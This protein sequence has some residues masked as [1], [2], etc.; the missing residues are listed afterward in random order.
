MAAQAIGSLYAQLGLDT[1]SFDTGIAKARGKL[2]DFGKINFSGAVKAGLGEIDGALKS[3]AG[4]AGALG[5]VLGGLGIAGTAAAAAIAVAFT[6]ARQAMAFGD[7]I[8]DTANKLRVT[9]DY[10]QELRFAAHQLGGEF[11]DADEALEGF[12]KTFGLARSGLSAKAIKPFAALGLDPKSFETVQQALN[13]V[14]D[15][16]SGLGDAA[17]QAAVADK[18][19]LTPLLP[20]IREG[21]G[22]ID[23]LRKAAHELGYVMDADLIDKAGDANDKFE[24][25]QAVLDVQFKSAMVDA[26]PL[27][28]QLTEFMTGAAK[29]A[30]DFARNIQSVSDKLAYIGTHDFGGNNVGND[31][32][33][34]FGRMAQRNG[35]RQLAAKADPV[36]QGDVSITNMR[37]MFGGPAAARPDG[38]V[39]D[40][41]GKRKAEAEAERKAAEAE[42]ERKAALKALTDAMHEAEKASADYAAS[43][44]D[45]IATMGMSADQIR[46]YRIAQEAA[47]A[48]TA[49]LSKLIT[50]LGAKYDAQIKVGREAAGVQKTV[51]DQQSDNITTLNELGIIIPSVFQNAAYEMDEAAKAARDLR[52]D[53]E[54]IAYAIEDHDWVSAFAGLVNVL[55]KVDTAF[56]NAK[57]SKDKFAAVAMLAQG[58]GGAIGGTGGA[59]V[60]GAGSGALAGLGLASSLTTLGLAVPGPGWALAAGG[61]VLGAIGGIFGSSKAKK[62]AK[63]QAEA[64]RQA[65]EAA[66]Q[67]TI[68]DTEFALNVALLRAQG[69]ET[70]ALNMEREKE[71]A[72]L[73]GI[74]QASVDLQKQLWAVTDAA[75]KAAKVEEMRASI[76]GRIDYITLTEA[77]KRQKAYEKE[78]AAA[79]ELGDQSLVGLID[80]LYAAQDATAA[81][82][83]ATKALEVANDNAT[84]AIEQQVA[85]Q[86]AMNDAATQAIANLT[87]LSRSLR[88]FAGEVGGQAGLG[89][90]YQGARA[91]LLAEASSGRLTNLQSLGE[92]FLKQSEARFGDSRAYQRDAA[93]V[94]AIALAGA[95]TADMRFGAIGQV[96]GNLPGFAS[97]GS[98]VIGGNPGI[99]QN[100]LSIN[101]QPQAFVGAGELLTVTPRGASNDNSS[102]ALRSEVNAL[103]QEVASL[104]S[105]TRRGADAAEE[106]FDLLRAGVI[107]VR[108]G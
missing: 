20:A 28:M 103:R 2:S 21:A 69:E 29:A 34:L 35:L 31:R 73:Q 45:D 90:N 104:R 9:T 99:D 95:A 80:K 59:V 43:L 71:I 37:A 41:E 88:E 32:D 50:D 85:A 82:A 7:E 5:N 53:I 60:G 101:G 81:Q 77:E 97:G 102:A 92:A 89:G 23:D 51:N 3:T 65:E 40:L 24:A 62:Q 25:L 86:Q 8:A 27:V 106:T 57:D 83:A 56:K 108:Q 84:R 49:A 94:R 26:I 87:G 14:I 70:K 67:Q 33:R 19:G 68:A 96:F 18:L 44:L 48:P 13:A 55:A 16:I 75:E 107:T 100:V 76:Q 72:R 64:Q 79:K 47:A 63:R 91:A 66:R 12:T 1:A 46:D 78:I 58:V 15:K 98:M 39:I 105:E 74:S 42:R 54:D 11:T 52:F 22:A 30:G 6:G 36:G 61:A 93:L 38:Q 10:L 17:E 4:R